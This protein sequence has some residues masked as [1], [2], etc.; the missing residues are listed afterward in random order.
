M[1]RAPLQMGPTSQMI[2]SDATAHSTIRL[3]GQHRVAIAMARAENR[4]ETLT[5]EPPLLQEV[6]HELRL[7]EEDV[8]QL[9]HAELVHL[10]D[11]LL[12]VKVLLEGLHLSCWRAVE[13][14]P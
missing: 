5:R 3:H 7:G 6:P 13:T 9:V 1:V 8:I 4:A 12:A 11:V 10:V 14:S 2:K